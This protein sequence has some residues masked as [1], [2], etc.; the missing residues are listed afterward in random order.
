MRRDVRTNRRAPSALK[1]ALGTG[2]TL[3]VS[4][5]ILVACRPPWRPAVPSAVGARPDGGRRPPR[6]ATRDRRFDDLIAQALSRV[7]A[8]DPEDAVKPLQQAIQLSPRHPLGHLLLGETYA[9]L[10]QFESAE[11]SLKTATESA[12]DLA[13]SLEPRTLEAL[14]TFYE[15]R[16]Q[17]AEARRTWARLAA[18]AD[19]GSL[20]DGGAAIR[21]ASFA[22]LD[23]VAEDLDRARA[24]RD[25]G[26][27]RAPDAGPRDAA[28]DGAR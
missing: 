22:A 24:L 8:R 20:S 1:A 15:A 25:G 28:P 16:H 10:G 3:V 11:A 14:A 4:L 12:F 18:L 2:L 9:K 23:K 7:E 21:L 5:S 6:R 27:A 13:P 19:G 26:A 17:E